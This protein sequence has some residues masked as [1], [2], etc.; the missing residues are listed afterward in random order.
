[1]PF[2][3]KKTEKRLFYCLSKKVNNEH[4]NF[5]AVDVYYIINRATAI[6]LNL[7]LCKIEHYWLIRLYLFQTGSKDNAILVRLLHAIIIIIIIILAPS[8]ISLKL[9]S[10]RVSIFINSLSPALHSMQTIVCF[11]CIPCCYF[12][13]L[14]FVSNFLAPTPARVWKEFGYRVALLW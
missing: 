13:D 8:S 11:S 6:T 1:M 7:I 3:L 5:E 12:T 9:H 14:K 2:S 10:V 4:D